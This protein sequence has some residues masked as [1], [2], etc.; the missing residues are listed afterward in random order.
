MSENEKVKLTIDGQEVEIE[1]GKYVLD[2]ARA[3]NIYIPTL[4]HHPALSPYGAC[5]LCLV[6]VTDRG[7]TRIVTSCTY[8]AKEGLIVRTNTDRVNHLRKGVMELLLARCPNV[9]E[10]REL[11]E[12]MGVKGGRLYY[13]EEECILCGLCV[14]ICREVMGV[15]AIGFVNRGDRRTI[16]TPFGKLSDVCMTCGACAFVCPTGA[17][18]LDKISP[19]KPK[20]IPNEFDLGLKHRTPIYVP[21]PQA[22]PNIPVIDRER[23]IYFNRGTCRACEKFC[24]ANAIRFDQEDELRE[25][26]VGAV[27]VA[28]GYRDF[29]AKTKEEYGYGH[30]ANVVTSL[31]FERMMC[32]SGPFEGHIRRPSDGRPPRKVAFI[33]CVGSRDVRCGNDYCSSVCCMY[34]T[35]EAVIAREHDPDIEPTIFYMDIRAFG[36]EFEKYYERAKNEYGVRYIRSRIPAVEEDIKTK[37]LILRYETEEGELRKERFD[38]VVLSIGLIPSDF[39]KELKEKLGIDVNEYGF[40]ERPEFAPLSTTRE[41][42]YACGAFTGPKDIPE[43]VMEASGA[44]ARAGALLSP[45]RGTLTREKTYP[46]ELDI[47]GEPLR[48]GVFVCH[49]GIN[50]GGVVD[51]PAVTEYAKSLEFVVHAE[52]NL[53]SCSEDALQNLVAK[54]KEHK[55][56]RVVV[57]SCSPRT[58]E[59]LFRET[60][61]EA[62]LNPYLFE[63]ANIRDQC[64]WV[65]MNDKRSATEKAKDLVRMAVAKC[66]LLTPLYRHKIPVIKRGLVIG[67]GLAGMTAARSLAANGFE[68]YLIEKSS[69]LGGR[70]RE[71]HFTIDGKRTADVLNSLISEI[72][73]ND[74]IT[75]YRNAEIKNID[76][77]VGNFKTTIEVE[78]REI[79]LEHG[80]VVVATGAEEYKPKEYL[81]GKSAQVMTQSELERK[82][83]QGEFSAHNVVMIQCVGSRNEEHPNCSRVCCQEAV[84]NALKI[85]ELSPTTEVTVL[86]RD[87]RTYGYSEIQ[88]RKARQQGVVFIRFDKEREPQVEQKQD[89]SLLVRVFEPLLKEEIELPADYLV[90]S[91]GTVANPENE[92]LARLLKVPLTEDGFFLEAHMKLRPVD[93]ATEGIFLCGTAHSPK[94]M[95]ESI[96]QAEAAASRACTV[97]AKDWVLA[98]GTTA[99]VDPTKCT[100]CG[101]CV[102]VCAYKAVALSEDGTHAEVNEA[103]CK[104]C[105]VCAS[106]CRCGAIDLKGFLDNQISEML[107][108]ALIE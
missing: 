60:L 74:K 68:T 75:V 20:R 27:I 80:V 89:G 99:V 34:A 25:V 38:L 107:S 17:I 2:A 39:V 42:I 71:I 37:D 32:A 53:Y 65:H 36:K 43:T 26:D 69:R 3:L 44:A 91:A 103:L 30:C 61:A 96:A 95:E 67:G 108:A 98:E 54:I 94:L 59:P 31:E 40:C 97:L 6:E 82:L 35:K 102:E 58:H 101:V 79:E 14:R 77:F 56:N 106:S 83:A 84:K 62:G 48:I 13:K 47:R 7:R 1:K 23:C 76:G 90:L 24:E 15:G 105:G 12:S 41:G 88:Y 52:H 5:R 81:Y 50:I 100:A 45:A 92:K 22:V 104:G 46:P 87:L 19:N 9:T 11:A 86:Y 66:R 64:S 72:E 93:F 70:M 10:I 63:M 85:K 33:Q 18:H 51:V 73:N 57:A 16:N 8:P 49:C 4:C 55:L 28:P 78:G 21:F 29:Q